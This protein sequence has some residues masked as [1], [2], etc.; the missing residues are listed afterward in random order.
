MID[1]APAVV[2]NSESMTDEDEDDEDEDDDDEDDEDMMDTQGVYDQHF[3]FTIF[4]KW[5]I[6]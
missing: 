2:P 4:I 5:S 1:N 6:F 3:W